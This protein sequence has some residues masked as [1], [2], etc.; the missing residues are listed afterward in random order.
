[1]KTLL[2]KLLQL[3][4]GQLKLTRSSSADE[5]AN[6]NFLVRGSG[7]VGIVT[8]CSSHYAVQGHRGWYQLK[9]RIRLTVSD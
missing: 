1:M 6:V 3:C 5:I 8:E 2:D 9:A 7:C 4:G